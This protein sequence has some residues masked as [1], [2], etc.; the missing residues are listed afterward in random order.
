MGYISNTTC[1][2]LG[3][4]TWFDGDV[5]FDAF[6]SMVLV[7]FFVSSSDSACFVISVVASGGKR[8]PPKW[9]KFFWVWVCAFVALVLMVGQYFHLLH[10]PPNNYQK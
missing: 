3:I 9:Q 2:L 1:N 7:I 4:L 8:E 5:W 10:N 6:F